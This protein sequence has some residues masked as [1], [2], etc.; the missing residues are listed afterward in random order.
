MNPS[1]STGARLD[2]QTLTQSPTPL[3]SETQI[4]ALSHKTARLGVEIGANLQPGQSVLINYES[5]HDRQVED[6]IDVC[7]ENK[8]GEIFL[9]RFDPQVRLHKIQNASPQDLARL[10]PEVISMYE[11]WYQKRGAR[12]SLVGEANP[13]LF[14]NC[15]QSRLTIFRGAKRQERIVHFDHVIGQ[16]AAQWTLVPSATEGWA[17]QVFPHLNPNEA[18]ASL[19]KAMETCLRLDESDP[20]AAWIDHLESLEKRAERLNGMGISQIHFQTEGTDLKVGLPRQYKFIGGRDLTVAGVKFVANLPTEEVFTTPDYRLTNGYITV[21]APVLING[22]IVSGLKVWFNN[23][24]VEKFEVDQGREAI[25]ALFESGLAAQRLGEVALVD[26]SSRVAQTEHFYFSA[27]FDENKFDHVAIGSAYTK[28]LEGG[29]KM[30][31]EQLA[32]VGCNVASSHYDVTIGSRM[33]ASALCGH[34]GN[35][36]VIELQRDGRLLV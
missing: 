28:C 13:T 21:N 15:D 18:R 17:Q 26:C 3:L 2:S 1:Q 29:V 6:I 12:I 25:V 33:N 27:L 24:D 19:W 10:D 16:N 8:C 20:V 36:K 35:R 31:P 32:K 14:E 11:S 5:C 30:T 34:A 22:Q 4:L 9:D 7:K 23:G